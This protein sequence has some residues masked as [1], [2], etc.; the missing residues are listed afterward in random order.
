MCLTL[1]DF[2]TQ[3]TDQYHDSNDLLGNKTARESKAKGAIAGDSGTAKA[4]LPGSV[5][6]KKK[7]NLIQKPSIINVID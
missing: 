1:V 4:E 6:E 7:K 3:T 2:N 5:S